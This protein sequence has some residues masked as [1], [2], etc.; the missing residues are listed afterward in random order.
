MFVSQPTPSE[1][2]S[3]PFHQGLRA[4]QEKINLIIREM[5]MKPNYLPDPGLLEA[6]SAEVMALIQKYHPSMP[7][8]EKSLFRAI[9]DLT[10]IPVMHPTM[11]IVAVKTALKDAVRNLNEYLQKY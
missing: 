7:A 6:I 9:V 4:I 8:Q 3:T 10:E 1:P 11:Q 2:R 5:D